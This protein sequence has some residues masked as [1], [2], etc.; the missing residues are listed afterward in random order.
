MKALKGKIAT[1]PRTENGR[2][3]F[4]LHLENSGEI[5][6]C[7]SGAGLKCEGASLGMRVTLSG[8]HKTDLISSSETPYFVFDELELSGK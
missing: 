4:H 7:L 5:I 1:K 8:E 6:E 3:W 2:T